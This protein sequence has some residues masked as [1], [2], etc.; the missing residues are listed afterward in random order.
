MT[1]TAHTKQALT[2]GR[3]TMFRR[4]AAVVIATVAKVA[5]EP[6]RQPAGWLRARLVRRQALDSDSRPNLA[7]APRVQADRINVPRHHGQRRRHARPVAILVAAGALVAVTSTVSSGPA[8]ASSCGTVLLGGGAWLGGGGVDVKSNGAQQ[9]IG[10]GCSGRD[11]NLMPSQLGNG[12]QCVELAQRLYAARGW[13][14]ASGY[15][16]N[17]NTADEIFAQ[18][19]AMGMVA[20]PN[21]SIIAIAPGDMIIHGS[22]GYHVAIADSVV[23]NVVNAVEQNASGT[24]RTTYTISN[25]VLSGGDASGAIVGIVHS[26]RN[27]LSPSGAKGS[28][29]AVAPNLDGRLEVFGANAAGGVF[30]KWQTAPGGNWSAWSE[31]DGALTQVAA[32][33]NADGRLELFGVNAAGGVFHKWQTAPGG[34]W[35][36]WSQFDGA[37]R[38]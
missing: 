16:P 18:A 36:A 7:R 35:S 28:S 38:R 10:I 2:R 8:Y 9:G 29:I 1:I 17:V 15:F 5:T 26:P 3:R 4:V 31:F 14:P 24:G 12:W 20:V 11:A 27:S 37:L 22:P 6:A 30:H 25:G 32:A 33:A 21:R 19:G 34:N 23:G 13:G